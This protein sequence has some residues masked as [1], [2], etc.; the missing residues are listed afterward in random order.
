[1][2]DFD[3]VFGVL[4]L[5]DREEAVDSGELREWIE[6]R[7]AARSAARAARDFATSDAIRDELL[8]EGIVLED[9]PSGTRWKRQ[10]Q[11]D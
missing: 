9:G 2:D 3:S 10:S 8:A 1:M 7:I 4:A 11:P 5:R 6:E